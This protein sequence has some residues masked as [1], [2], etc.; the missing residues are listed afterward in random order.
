MTEASR[1]VLIVEDET[2]LRQAIAEQ[3]TDRGFRVEQAESGEAALESSRILPSTSSP[4][5]CGC[6]ASTA[7]RSSGPSR[8]TRYRRHRD[9]R[10]RHGE[11]CR[12]DQAQRATA[13]ASRLDRRTAALPVGARAAAPRDRRTV[14]ARTRGTHRGGIVGKSRAIAKLFQLLETVAATS[15]AILV[16]GQTAAQGSRARASTNLAAAYTGSSHQLQRHSRDAARGRVVRPR[17]RRLHGRRR[18]TAGTVEQAHK[19]RSSSR[20]SRT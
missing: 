8:P 2:P 5:T 13:S 16:T 19:A 11:I 3:L 20:R 7:Q 12:G 9:H 4:R 1:H 18:D 15:G 14:P 17:A 6:R 10:L